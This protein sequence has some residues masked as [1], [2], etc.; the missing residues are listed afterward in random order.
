MERAAGRGRSVA[1][2][3]GRGSPAV[4]DLRR[5]LPALAA[6]MALL[7]AA[8]LRFAALAHQPGL[9]PDEGAEAWDAHLLLTQPGFHPVFFDDDAGREALYGYLVAA[10]FHTFGE[11]VYV[12][13]AVSAAL[14]VLGVAATGYALRHFGRA[15]A[16]A[17]MAWTAGTL[18]LVCVA[19]DGERNVLVPLF[20][21]LAIAAL[22]TWARRPGRLTAIVAGAVVAGGLWT[23]Q[24]LKLTPLLVLLWL[25]WLRR[26]NPDR[27]R[28]LRAGLGWMIAAYL[29][30]AAPM[31][32]TA[33]TDPFNY[34]GRDVVVSPLNRHMGLRGYGTHVLRTLGMFIFDGD[35]NPRQNVD[36]LPLLSLPLFV[37]AVLG[38]WRAWVNRRSS[39]HSLLLIGMLV[40]MLPPLVAVEG[41]SPHFLR[42]LGIAPFLAGLIGLGALELHDRAGK[43]LHHPDGLQRIVVGA[44][45][46]LLAITAVAS[47]EAYLHRSAASLYTPY[48]GDLVQL[49]TAG[50]QEAGTA[51]VTNTYDSVDVLFLDQ[52]AE[53]AL[54][55]PGHPL[56]DPGRYSKIV[57]LS[58]AALAGAVGPALAETA[59]PIAWKPDGEPSVWS[60][61]Q[62]PGPPLRADQPIRT[63]PG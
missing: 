27:Y 2:L 54:V 26:V 11:S 58:Q 29:V 38:A 17:G 36:G 62:S 50:R 18:W 16:L 24:P 55:R 42:S 7:A 14:G 22:I 40:F 34:F 39:A 59:V 46:A 37:L 30:V 53:P 56:P 9:F 25:V 3:A 33:L 47:G 6:T 20:A 49:A 60:L 19:R 51:V 63:G 28:S 41:G 57:A 31:F 10:A 48:S 52:S 12:L 21:A 45:T 44:C 15:V 35:P 4:A 8:I 32:W 5:W 23:Y 61:R 1:V 13:R 43:V